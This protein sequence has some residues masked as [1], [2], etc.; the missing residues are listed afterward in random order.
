MKALR[1]IRA[2]DVL[3]VVAGVAIAIALRYSMLDFKSA[4]FLD[5]TKG[6]YNT[7]KAGGFSAF[8]ED[9]SN[10]NVPYLYLL[11]LV[12]RFLPDLPA[13]IATKV[14]SLLADFGMA[15]LAY[16]IVRLR[17][18]GTPLPMFAA[19]AV[20]FAPT[21][22]LNSAFWGQAD[23]LYTAALVAC[24][25]CLLIQRDVWAMAAF[26]VSVAFKAQGV[27]LLPLLAALA[28]RREL[29]WQTILLVPAIMLAAL[30]PAWAA[31]RLL[32][33][34]IMIYPAQAGQY[35]QLSMHAPSLLSWIPDTGKLYPYFYPVGLIAAA[36]AALCFVLLVYRS[37]AKLTAPLL[38]ELAAISVML[39]PFLLPKMHER[40]FYPADVVTILLAFYRP[41]LYFVPIGMSVISF[42]SYQPAIFGA[43]PV[44]IAL[45]AF[46]VL[47]LLILLIRDALLQLYGSTAPPA[48]A[49][50]LGA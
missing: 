12:I 15:W 20:L 9:F 4:D 26:G 21:I 10:Y 7:L 44:S 6:W 27:F 24:L 25:Y 38:V 33:D 23:A 41:R 18:C 36:A 39:M 32:I 2:L 13:V 3:I 30:I 16:R 31:G 34:L 40:Y 22:A 8:R 35:E 5:Y 11:Y 48:E 19:F 49:V 29:R 46:G 50:E 1:R 43:E 28:L 47:V 14:P 17:Y 42:F 37:R 45:L